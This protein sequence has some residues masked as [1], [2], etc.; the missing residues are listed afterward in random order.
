VIRALPE[1]AI[2]NGKDTLRRAVMLGLKAFLY[3]FPRMRG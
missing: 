1:A 3:D 2:A